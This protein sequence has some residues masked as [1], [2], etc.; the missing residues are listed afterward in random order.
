MKRILVAVDGSEISMR[1]VERAAEL[2]AKFHAELIIVDVVEHGELP[3]FAS[4]DVKLDKMRRGQR[5]SADMAQLA[6][7]FARTTLKQAGTVAEAHG[8]Q[9]LRSEIRFGDA[10]EEILQ[11]QKET[12]ADAIVIGSRGHGRLAGMLLGSV[13]QKIASLAPCAVIIVR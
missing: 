1:A 13:S 11:L 6:E 4:M 3:D 2:A 9:S 8:G 12:Q 7:S 10:A 5:R